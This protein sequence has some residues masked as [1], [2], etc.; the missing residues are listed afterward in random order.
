MR[1]FSVTE[2]ES[3]E[4][5]YRRRAESEEKKREMRAWCEFIVADVGGGVAKLGDV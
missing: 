2:N 3:V 1:L 4:S 5:A